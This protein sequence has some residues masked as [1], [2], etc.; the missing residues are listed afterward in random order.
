M[1]QRLFQFGI[2]VIFIA[3]AAIAAKGFIQKRKGQNI[4]LKSMN[5]WQQAD[6]PLGFKVNDTVPP[7]DSRFIQLTA[8]E[9]A[10][11]PTMTNTS[12]A[13]GTE[14]GALTYNAQ[15]FWSDNRQRGG[16]HTGDDING[17]GGMNTDLGDPVYAIGN[18]LVIYRGQPSPGWGSTLVVAHRTTQGDI[19]L[20]MYA[21]LKNIHSAYGDI[22]YR[23]ETIGTV[24]TANLRYPAHLHLEMIDS[25]GVHIGHGYTKSSGN[26]I[27]PSATIADLKGLPEENLHIPPLAVALSE[28]LSQQHENI[29]LQ[30]KKNIQ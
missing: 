27:N 24:G 9:R 2:A 6:A 17:I 26:S 25:S 12:E 29:I 7:F 28:K 19:K 20:S 8:F 5:S 4:P 22:V 1:K 3:V 15:P 11:I 13:M 23:G 30:S 18:G 16:H 14:H 10:L 21:H